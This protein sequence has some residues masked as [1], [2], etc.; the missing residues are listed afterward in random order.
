MKQTWKMIRSPHFNHPILVP[1]DEVAIEY[2]QTAKEGQIF[3]IDLKVQRNV[4]QHKLFWA[5]MNFVTH[6][7]D[8]Y[9][10]ATDLVRHLKIATGNVREFYGYDDKMYIEAISISFESMDQVKFQRFF[11]SCIDIICTRFVPTLN[12]AELEREFWGYLDK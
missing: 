1:D 8:K 6:H 11:K 2:A 4:K 9:S 10:N 5:L 3:V 7:S 12:S